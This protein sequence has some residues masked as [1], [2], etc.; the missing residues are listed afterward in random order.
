MSGSITEA[1]AVLAL[2]GYYL[3]Q[4]RFP[5]AYECNR[6]NNLPHYTTYL[7]LYDSWSAATTAALGIVSVPGSAISA[8]EAV[9]NKRCM[10]CD[11]PVKDPERH[12]RHCK[13]CRRSLFRESDEEWFDNGILRVDLTDLGDWDSI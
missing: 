9:A 6:G 7:R 8:I 2:R 10:R 1:S 13:A 12:V 4:G 5:K 11:A 3:E